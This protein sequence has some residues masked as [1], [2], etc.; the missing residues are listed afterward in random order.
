MKTKMIRTMALLMLCLPLTTHSQE[1]RGK[2]QR[3]VKELKTVFHQIPKEKVQLLDQLA[4]RMVSNMGDTPYTVVFV[5]QD[6]DDMGQLAMIWLRTGLMYYGLNDKFKV[7]SAGLD[8]ANETLPGLA[9]LKNDG[10]KVSNAQ[11]ESLFTY[12]VRYGSDSWTIN[13]K[14]L[15]S[16]HL[17]EDSSVKVYVQDGL[18]DRNA[19]VLFENKAVIAGEMIYVATQ[20]DAIIKAKMNN[21]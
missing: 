14:T 4:A 11:G 21:P 17:D 19:E 10:F 8:T 6:N 13:R 2:I 5:D 20:V 16:L 7:E 3:S 12:S 1:L 18:T 15:E 9:L